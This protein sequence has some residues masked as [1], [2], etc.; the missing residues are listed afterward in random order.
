MIIRRWIGASLVV[1]AG[2][3]VAGSAGAIEARISPSATAQA[4]AKFAQ[5]Q[6][7][8]AVVRQLNTGDVYE[9][10]I[11]GIRAE[12]AR[13]H[14][15]LDVY[16]ANGDN[17]REAMLLQQ[18]VAT[19]PDGII[20]GWGFADTLKPGIDA[21][22]AAGIPITAFDVGVKPSNDVVTIDQGDHKMMQKI[23]Q[24]LTADLPPGNGKVGVIYAYV[25]GYQAL[26]R[27]NEVWKQFLASNPRI[28]LVATVGVV[29]S[30]T[31]S[32]TA[33]QT[34][35]AL[36]AHPDV[37][38]VVAPYDEFAKGATLAVSQLGLSKKVKVYGMDVSTA[39]IAV[40]T[41]PDSPWVVTATTD[42]IN[43]GSV[44]LRTAAAK[45]A[46]QLTG[47][48]LSIEPLAITQKQLLD[49]NVRNVD[50][51]RQKFPAL[52]TP[53]VSLAPWMESLK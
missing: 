21:A 48:E 41:Q 29:N 44:V 52:Q 14:I 13:L 28:Q 2:L 16:D 42:M 46:G 25:A 39:D 35:A 15:K 24:Q 4:P 34:R 10:W 27:R 40:M 47:N 20:V 53:S 31:A 43:V 3:C 11:A 7:R 45:V 19:K 32:Q 26:D 23:L 9:N 5:K 51:L 22:N 30:N 6:V 36:T 50:Q 17:A 1:A 18:A 8:I 33:D 49:A 37:V 38:A 12:A